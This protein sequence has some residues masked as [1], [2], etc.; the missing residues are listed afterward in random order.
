MM[1]KLLPEKLAGSLTNFFLSNAKERMV[2]LLPQGSAKSAVQLPIPQTPYD[3]YRRNKLIKLL[4]MNELVEFKSVLEVG[5]G[6]GDLL[7]EIKKYNPR[8]LYGVDSDPG[9]IELAGKF[10]EG[11]Q[12]DLMVSDVRRLPFPERSFDVV[13]LMFELQHILDEKQLD[14]VIY[15][16]CR[17]SRQWVVL[18]EDTSPVEKK[19]EGSIRRPVEIYK[20]AFKKK[21]FYLRKTDFLDVSAS[22]YVFTGKSN[23]WH[24][25]RWLLSPLLYLMGFPKTWMRP[26]ISDGELPASKFALVLQKLSL[27]FMT[28]LDEIVK[29]GSGTT[30]MR[31]EREQLFRRG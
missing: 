29:T 3:R 12:V 15:E 23:P 5:C 27:P 30:V 7:A 8:E 25:I 14:K 13:V 6:V 1:K 11:M 9:M 22:Q 20:E 31:F 16:A 17:L 26:P 2:K 10:L 28:S 24:W 19:E 21:R 18:V 4:K